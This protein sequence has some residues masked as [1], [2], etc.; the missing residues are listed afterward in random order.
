MTTTTD[1]PVKAAH[2]LLRKLVPITRKKAAIT[3]GKLAAAFREVMLLW[4]EQKKTGVPFV[5]RMKGLREVL[6][7]VWPQTREWHYL[8]E[9]CND[10]GLVIQDCPGDSTCGRLKP[11]LAHE[12]G[13]LCRC[14]KGGRFREKPIVVAT[15]FAQAGRSSKPTR[16]GR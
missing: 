3:E 16:L 14:P 4:D 10:T 9:V 2:D 1:D 12:Y 11:H 7:A 8:C 13:T 15:D 6:R 5:E